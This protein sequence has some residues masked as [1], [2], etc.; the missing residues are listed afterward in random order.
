MSAEAQ[1]ARKTVAISVLPGLDCSR[2]GMHRSCS[3]FWL[4][5]QEVVCIVRLRLLNSFLC[6]GGYMYLEH[7]SLYFV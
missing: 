1:I 2:W 4:V 3:L 7:L 6:E 5:A